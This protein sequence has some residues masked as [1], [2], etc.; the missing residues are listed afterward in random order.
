MFPWGNSSAA[1]DLLNF[2]DQSLDYHLSDA[3]IN[4]G[5]AYTAPVGSYPAGA[6]PYGAL[7]MSGNNWEWI[8][9]WYQE[10]YYNNSPFANPSGP[11][12]GDKRLQRG[13][14]W[15]SLA[16]QSRT[17]FRQWSNPDNSWANDGFRCVLGASSGSTP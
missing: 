12:S 17:T 10:D 16:R 13:G 4:D 7:D 1:G 3:S 2:A 5:Y 15:S 11:E 6:S 14:A 9:D 8:A